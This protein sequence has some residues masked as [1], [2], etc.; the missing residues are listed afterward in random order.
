M[1]KYGEVESIGGGVYAQPMPN[2]GVNIL[3]NSHEYPTDKIWMD[4]HNVKALIELLER[5]KE[6]DQDKV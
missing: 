6:T 4:K 2:G 3:A 1:S 5:V